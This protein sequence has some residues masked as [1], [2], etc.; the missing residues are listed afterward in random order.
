MN[1]DVTKDDIDGGCWRNGYNCPVARAVL[2][3]TG[4]RGV[5]VS[6]SIIAVFDHELNRGFPVGI[7][8]VKK[9]AVKWWQTPPDVARRIRNYDDALG[10]YPFEFDL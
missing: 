7:R 2:R 6:G 1:I 9:D 8:A 4:M 3:A 5:F 10:M